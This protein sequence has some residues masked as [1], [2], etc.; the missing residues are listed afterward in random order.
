MPGPRIAGALLI[1][2]SIGGGIGA[3][4]LIA[5]A[6]WS[7]LAAGLLTLAT[8]GMAVG[9]LWTMRSSWSDTTWPPAG[10]DLPPD[11]RLRRALRILGIVL[12]APIPII[13]ALLAWV[14]AEGTTPWNDVLLIALPAAAYGA[15]GVWLLRRSRL[16]AD[17][18]AHSAEDDPS[19]PQHGPRRGDDEW[20]A[21]GGPLKGTFLTRAMLPLV[22]IGVWSTLQLLN[23]VDE[24]PWGGLVWGAVV[25]VGLVGWLLFVRRH[26]TPLEANP[27]ERLIRFRGTTLGWADLTRAELSADPPWKGAA[28]T[29]ILSLGDGPTHRGRVVL[30]RKGL[31][32]LSDDETELLLRIIEA[33]AVDIPR[34]K[35]D[36]RGR[37]SRQLYPNSLTKVDAAELIAH[38]P[39]ADDELPIRMPV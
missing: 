18:S 30:R 1:V 24:I 6:P 25:I 26:Q 16:D 12:L 17:I 4:W 28:H 37:F 13:V 9:V 35:D 11:V 8:I 2:V 15:M 10:R 21:L 27:A 39:G 5:Q 22:F 7:I 3:G 34:D 36:P 23:L 20:R 19:P 31:L 32:E 14:I 33:S 38:P 29:L